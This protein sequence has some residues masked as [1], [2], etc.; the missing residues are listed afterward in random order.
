MRAHSNRA[1]AVAQLSTTSKNREATVLPEKKWPW[2]SNRPKVVGSPELG[3]IDHDHTIYQK[4]LLLLRIE[5]HKLSTKLLYTM[6]TE[7]SDGASIL[8]A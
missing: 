6:L 7:I 1:H 8:A 4:I 5:T 2:F 3:G